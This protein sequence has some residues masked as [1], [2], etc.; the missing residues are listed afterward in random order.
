L[1]ELAQL[2]VTFTYTDDDVTNGNTYYYSGA[3]YNSIAD[4]PRSDI[5]GARP[6]RLPVVPGLVQN[7]RTS[8]EGTTV[9][10]LW[11][12]PLD[13]GGS[14]VV[15]YIVMRGLDPTNM[16]EIAEVGIIQ[17]YTDENLQRGKTFYYKV[18][19]MNDIGRGQFSPEVQA[20]IERIEEP[21]SEGTPWLLIVALLCVSLITVGAIAST[22]SGRYRWGLLLGP[23]TT[24]LKRDEVLDNKTRHALLGII[25][26]NPGIHYQ[27]IKREFEL[28]NG[29]AAYHLDVLER[30]NFIRSVRDGRLKRFYSTDTKVPTDQRATPEELR[31]E[32]LELVVANPGISQKEVVNEL[33]VESDTAGYHLRAMVADGTIKD[34]RRGKYMTYYRET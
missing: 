31:E 14:A 12:A 20:T 3:A 33:G 22:E 23:L 9:T 30:E 26:T 17:S 29:V 24:R 28:K 10:L 25:I 7:L 8:V 13:D 1:V 15:G 18:A 5:V 2:S 16:E 11:G 27:A 19:P 21:V 6:F 4:G 34:E 32:I